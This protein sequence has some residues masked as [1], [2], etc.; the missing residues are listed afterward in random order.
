MQQTNKCNDHT[1][2]VV[3]V[4]RKCDN[5][6]GLKSPLQMYPG[7]QAPTQLHVALHCISGVLYLCHPLVIVLLTFDIFR[8]LR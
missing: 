2:N 7:F 4:S 5:I 6:Y 1:N 8:L 3:K